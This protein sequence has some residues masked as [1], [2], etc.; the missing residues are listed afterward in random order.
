MS[1]QNKFE[2]VKLERIKEGNYA[3]LSIIRPDKLNALQ[4]QTLREIA[5]A[6]ETVS[7]LRRLTEPFFLEEDG[8]RDGYTKREGT[9][10]GVI[11]AGNFR[12]LSKNV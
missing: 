5:E 8:G 3:V 1:E 9:D 6:L 4:N 2:H 7:Q 11:T 10:Q 12:K